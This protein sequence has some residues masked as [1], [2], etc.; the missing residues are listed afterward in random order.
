[1]TTK[2]DLDHDQENTY[3]RLKISDRKKVNAEEVVIR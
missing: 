3:A 2:T 1:M